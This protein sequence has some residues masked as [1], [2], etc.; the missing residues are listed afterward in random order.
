M[1]GVSDV[2]QFCTFKM[3][4]VLFGVEIDRV[5][6]IIRAQRVARIPQAPSRVAGLIN[7]R[8]HIV[9]TI[10]LRR[11][12]SMGP[13]TGDDE[14]ANII[15]HTGDGAVSL[16]ADSVGD[17]L[18]LSLD[19]FEHP[20]TNLGAALHTLIRGVY[21]LPSELMMVLSIDDVIDAATSAD[22][23]AM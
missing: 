21:K 8:G 13:R 19:A 6:E 7:L 16:L 1:S 17:I 11:C 5:Q 4:E 10:D 9:P 22:H 15:I 3:D 23:D 20:P 18:M 2:R 12:L 14:V